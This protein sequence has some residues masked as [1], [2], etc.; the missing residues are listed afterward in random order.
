MRSKKT[1]G[2]GELALG[3][4]LIALGIFSFAR[5]ESA[6]AAVTYLYGSLALVTG[7]IDTVF[8]SQ[9]AAH[10]FGPGLSLAGG[11]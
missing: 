1:L 2:W 3:I 8:T 9:R 10:G 7:I 11:F 5:P 4:L 6:L